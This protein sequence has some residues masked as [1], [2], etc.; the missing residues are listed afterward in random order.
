MRQL[1]AMLLASC[2]V[3][4]CAPELASTAYQPDQ[5][6]QTKLSGT[7]KAGHIAVTRTLGELLS[8]PPGV[9]EDYGIW[10]GKHGPGQVSARGR[11]MTA[12]L[13]IEVTERARYGGVLLYCLT[14]NYEERATVIA[15]DDS[16]G[17]LHVSVR[18]GNDGPALAEGR[19]KLGKR[20]SRRDGGRLL[21]FVKP[22]PVGRPGDYFIKVHDGTGKVLARATLHCTDDIAHP[23][24][25][26][27]APPEDRAPPGAG[28]QMTGKTILISVV[29][30]DGPIALPD[31]D[32]SAAV[33]AFSREE[34]ARR[35]DEPLP[36]LVP[37]EADPGFR[38]E[39][40]G[41]KLVATFDSKVSFTW[42]PPTE[43]FL[44]R[45]WVMEQ[46]YVP[47]G[48]WYDSSGWVLEQESASVRQ[49]VFDLD[50]MPERLHA[51]KGYRV[52]VQL[53]FCPGGLDFVEVLPVT[54]RILDDF[55]EGQLGM[56]TRLSNRVEF[57][58]K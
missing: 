22:V 11:R 44:T 12:R 29:N 36:R 2:L 14:E 15:G 41:S 49:V 52:A 13:G 23:W 38:V 58:V 43:F 21:L 9:D 10:L 57:T 51:V 6:T 50:L 30:P 31:W 35:A 26:W 28:W 37:E 46:P 40:H 1:A 27:R 3:A 45:W 48:H 7:G 20:K 17:P 24:I 8:Q 25:P 53:L 18:Y 16:L 33:A 47:V 42:L 34:L 4:S 39:I 54:S 55:C 32:G 56:R 5:R 19:G